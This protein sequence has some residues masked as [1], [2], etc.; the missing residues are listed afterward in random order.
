[1]TTARVH[2]TYEGDEWLELDDTIK[3][4]MRKSGWKWIEEGYDIDGKDRNIVFDMDIASKNAV[5][6]V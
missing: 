2:V 1:M 4:T 3:A 6:G 5:S